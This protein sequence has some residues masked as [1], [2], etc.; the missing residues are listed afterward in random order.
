MTHK[1]YF[2]NRINVFDVPKLNKE[3]FLFI[4]KI[5]SLEGEIN[6]LDQIEDKVLVSGLK[7]Q[8]VKEFNRLTKR[9]KPKEIYNKLVFK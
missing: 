5:I 7:Q 2:T 8:K 4:L 6:A 9:K 3:Q 1:E